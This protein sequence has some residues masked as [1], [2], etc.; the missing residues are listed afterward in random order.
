M[1]LRSFLHA[2][3]GIGIATLS[4][5]NMKW[6]WLAVIIVAIAGWKYALNVV[7]WT[8]VVLCIALVIGLEMINTVVEKLCNRIQPDRDPDIRDIKDISAGAVLIAAIASAI[9]GLIIFIPKIFA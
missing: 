7:E 4:E 3:R 8:A 9:V 2:F 1:N 5:R 6:H